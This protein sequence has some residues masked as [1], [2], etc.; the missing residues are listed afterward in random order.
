VFINEV[1]VD[2][3]KMPC[4]DVLMNSS[5]TNELVLAE[6]VSNV[7]NGRVVV[8]LQ[9]ADIDSRTSVH[10]K[11]SFGFIGIVDI[12]APCRQTF[13]A[14]DLRAHGVIGLFR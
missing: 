13:I 12:T 9:I 10:T 4:T 1:P 11:S 6:C 7:V 5:F 14:T 8:M 3:I 2:T